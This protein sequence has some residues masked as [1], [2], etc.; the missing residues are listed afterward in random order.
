MLLK[1]QIRIQLSS[2]DEAERVFQAVS[3]DNHPLPSGLEIEAK[4]EKKN[5]IFEIKSTRGI[6]S[7]GATIEDLM[8]AIDLSLRTTESLQ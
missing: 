4:R 7:L 2:E 3:P 1:A 5:L 6:D 8:S